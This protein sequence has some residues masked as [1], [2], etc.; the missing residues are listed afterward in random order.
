MPIKKGKGTLKAL[1]RFDIFKRK[2]SQ[3]NTRECYVLRADIKH[4]FDEIIK[5]IVEI[6]YRTESKLQRSCKISEPQFSIEGFEKPQI[7]NS[8]R[9]TLK[10]FPLEMWV[11]QSPL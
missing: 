10:R 7:Q 2:V 5:K 8:L 6:S 4:Y 3:N 1:E 11:I 9:R